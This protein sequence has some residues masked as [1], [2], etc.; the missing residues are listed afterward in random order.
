MYLDTDEDSLSGVYENRCMWLYLNGDQRL[1]VAPFHDAWKQFVLRFTFFTSQ[2][3]DQIRRALEMGSLPISSGWWL[4]PA[5]AT[6]E[7]NSR[8]R[9]KKMTHTKG[10]TS[11]DDC[12]LTS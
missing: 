3:H 10:L 5:K 2:S 4:D 12:C 8:L 9:K 6:T 11:V 7:I 1:W